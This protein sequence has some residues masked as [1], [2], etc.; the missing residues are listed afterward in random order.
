[1]ADFARHMDEQKICGQ[2][3]C[4]ACLVLDVQQLRVA[5]TKQ[6]RREGDNTWSLD[7]GLASTAHVIY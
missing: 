5:M 7:S 6:A 2:G 3:S 4:L 1:M